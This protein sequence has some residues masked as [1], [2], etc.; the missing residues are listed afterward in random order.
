MVGMKRTRTLLPV[1]VALVAAA[2]L[3][4]CGEKKETI[5]DTTARYGPGVT[6]GK[7]P[8]PPEYDRL[9]ERIEILE[10]PRVGNEKYHRHAVIHI[11]RD[12]ILI[13][14]PPNVGWLP[15]AKVYS[16]LHTHEPNGVI[17]MESVRPHPFKLGE[18]FFVWGVAFGKDSLGSLRSEGDKQ[19]WV[20]VNGKRVADP[21]NYLLREGDNIAVG[22]GAENSF[23]HEP[24][25]SALKTVDGKGNDEM[26]CT[27]A[28]PD[29]KKPESCK[30]PEE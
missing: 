13:P 24:D 3:A 15:Q 16:A 28:G 7:P 9:E 11:Y 17:H 25:T 2:L 19:L 5:G 23:P 30:V 20:Y 12:G 10:F 27:V 4:G 1:L 14:V 18:L 8:W 6:D 26:S 22:Y 29:G 21:A